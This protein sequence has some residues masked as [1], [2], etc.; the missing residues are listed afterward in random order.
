MNTA[1]T[2]MAGSERA[3]LLD[4]IERLQAVL[5]RFIPLLDSESVEVVTQTQAALERI[6]VEIDGVIAVQNMRDSQGQLP[7]WEKG[8]R[9]M[10]EVRVGA[11]GGADPHRE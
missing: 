7:N 2:Q 9:G 10:T 11:R 4:N 6:R 8:S 5:H 3:E 1:L